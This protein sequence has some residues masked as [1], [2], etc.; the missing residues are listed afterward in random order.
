MNR[1]HTLQIGLYAA[2]FAIIWGPKISIGAIGPDGLVR[3]YFIVISMLIVGAVYHTFP[4]IDLQVNEVSLAVVGMI[5]AIILSIISATLIHGYPFQIGDIFDLVIWGTYAMMLLT[6]PPLITR[7][8]ARRTIGAFLGLAGLGALFAL[9]QNPLHV[10]AAL[11]LGSLYTPPPHLSDLVSRSSGPAANPNRLAQLISLPLLITFAALYRQLSD[12]K[13]TLEIVV[14][15]G[16]AAILSLGIF[17]SYSRSGA[18]LTGVGLMAI[19]AVAFRNRL[20]DGD[21]RRLVFGVVIGGGALAVLSILALKP[22]LLGRFANLTNPLQDSSLQLR[23]ERWDAMLPIMADAILL[24]HG[25]SKYA[26]NSVYGYPYPAIDSGV[27]VWTYHYGIVGM[28]AA[29]YLLWNLLKLCHRNAAD[30]VFYRS[31]WLLWS[32]TT[33]AFA[34]LVGSVAIWFILPFFRT[35]QSFVAFLLVAVLILGIDRQKGKFGSTN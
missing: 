13:I 14:L 4:K 34:W 12:R 22:G 28:F 27:F 16:L 11:K 5:G 2:V 24:G 29:V 3:A 33:G 19:L 6:I 35:R 23:M 20:G 10:D 7:G 9:L 25:P 30:K 18:I 8:V 31:E 21:Y 32:T 15:S 1:K 17:Y 26:L